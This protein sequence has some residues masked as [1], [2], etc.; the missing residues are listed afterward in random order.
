MSSSDA[1][2][3]R[4][5]LA[6]W[7]LADGLPLV[8]D[9]AHSRGAY[10]RDAVSG[11]EYL[12]LY[13]FFAARPLG[14]NHPKLTDPDFL[15]HLGRIAV[16][17]PANCDVYTPEYASFVD[18]FCRRA[19]G[20]VFP[21]VFFVEGGSVAVENAM[22]AAIDWKT[23]KNLAA[24]RGQ[25]GS[26]VIHF[27]RAFHGRTGYALSATDPFDRRKVDY[28]PVFDWPRIVN[29]AMTF[30]FDAAALEAVQALEA[31]ARTQIDAAFAAHGDDIAAILIEPIQGEGGD[32]YFR[33][34]L[35]ADLRRIADER[36]VL[37]IFDEIQT[38]F[39]S[40]GAWWDYQH[41]G[42][43]PDLIVFGKKTSVCGFAAGSRIDEV[44]SVFAV[45]ARISSTF[46]GNLADMVRCERVIEIIEEDDLLANARTMGS[47]L[48]KLLNDVAGKT[49][50]VRNV[51]GRGLWA[52]FDMPSTEDREAL[53]HAC[54]EEQLLVLRCGERGVRMRAA[55]DIDADSVGR[56]GAQ[57]EAGLRRAFPSQKKRR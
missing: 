56:A 38:G 50:R 20:G 45:S 57:L 22:K 18:T 39:G 25:V 27:Q 32:N 26:K 10:L 44:D 43:T 2:Q 11:I 46:A 33:S 6:K 9:L 24:G 36:D 47:Y 17:K 37:L 21:H 52:A 7:V 12:D 5:V 49:R 41:H 14:F 23:R 55:L 28:F 34:E 51:R 40:T 1:T 53:I 8:C 15:A 4:D 54:F 16:H 48:L 19:L 13:S 3:V 31:E 30:P 29:P 35:L 42:V